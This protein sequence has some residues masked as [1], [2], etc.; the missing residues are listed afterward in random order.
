MSN[1]NTVIDELS[2]DDRQKADFMVELAYVIHSVEHEE[3]SIVEGYEKII[4]LLGATEIERI[5]QIVYPK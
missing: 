4:R 1:V 3:I 5:L 2:V